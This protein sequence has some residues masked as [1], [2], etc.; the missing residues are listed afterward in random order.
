MSCHPI[1]ETIIKMFSTF[2]LFA[3]A[4]SIIYNCFPYFEA[5][6]NNETLHRK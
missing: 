2:G 6:I 4:D 1:K 3:S 5:K